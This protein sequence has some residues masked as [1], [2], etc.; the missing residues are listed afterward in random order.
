MIDQRNQ[1]MSKKF[2]YSLCST[3]QELNLAR[4]QLKQAVI[5]AK[6]D[7]ISANCSSVNDTCALRGGTKR[8]WNSVRK[9]KA[10]L[11]K[12]QSSND[13]PMRKSDG[14]LYKTPEENTEV[15]RSHFH[16][17]YGRQPSFDV[18]VLD[19][20][21]QKDICL[22]C[23]YNPTENEI[24]KATQKLKDNG[25]G[26]SG[27]CPQVW[28]S[29][30]Q[31]ENGMQL[32]KSVITKF[33]ENEITPEEWEIGLLKVLPKK[34]DL[35]LPGNYRGIMLL[36]TAYK[37]VTIIIHNHLRPIAES[38]DQEA[39]CGF[40]PGR[41]CIDSIFTVKMAMKKRREH[42]QESWIL[43]LDLVKAFDRVPRELLWLILEKFGVP[44]KLISLLK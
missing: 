7:W 30:V 16:Q 31:N 5:K 20:L 13:R 1:A 6:N 25:P 28:K 44:K 32:L 2:M 34:G 9:L 33:W 38:L 24:R 15:F 43:F 37:I 23:D 39:Q 8:F 3:V 21:P 26:D 29:L 12:L 41:G 35:S 14:S 40:R 27:I 22:N 11:T 4:K 36:E 19:S 17:L 42:G 10:G 18:T